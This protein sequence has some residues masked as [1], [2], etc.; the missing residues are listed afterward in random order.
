M[1]AKPPIDKAAKN[2]DGNATY[3]CDPVL[4]ICAA[5]KAGLD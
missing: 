4:D 5:I 3:I 1:A 2:A